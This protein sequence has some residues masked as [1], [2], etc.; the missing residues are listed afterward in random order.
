[1]SA[2]AR[3]QRVTGFVHSRSLAVPETTG[4]GGGFSNLL[5]WAGE[6]SPAAAPFYP[7]LAAGVGRPAAVVPDTRFTLSVDA[8]SRLGAAW[9]LLGAWQSFTCRELRV[10]GYVSAPMA[11]GTLRFRPGLVYSTTGGTSAE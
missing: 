6:V 8:R 1:M 7:P 4:G 2:A 11:G 9:R 3:L 10:T 5:R